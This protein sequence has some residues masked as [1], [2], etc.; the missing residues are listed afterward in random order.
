MRSKLNANGYDTSSDPST[1]FSN[2]SYSDGNFISRITICGKQV[3][4]MT[5]HYLL[6]VKS[7][8]AKFLLTVPTLSLPQMVLDMVWE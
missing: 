1:W 2:A 3:S 6:N 4:G 5:F 8:K 7:A